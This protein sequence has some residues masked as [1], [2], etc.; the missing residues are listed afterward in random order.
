[1]TSFPVKASVVV[2]NWNGLHW[3]KGCFDA[4]NSQDFQDFE[5]ILADDASTDESVKFTLEHYPEVRVARRVVQGGFAKTANEGIRAASGEYIVLLNNDTL[6]SASW[7]QELVRAMDS[8]PRTVGSLA[9]SMRRMDNPDLI[10]SA[11]DLLTWYGQGLKR[12]NDMPVSGCDCSG[13]ILAA[14]A[15]A[16]LYRRELLDATGGFDEHFESYL[17]DI[18]LGLR[19]SLLGYACR[20]VPVAVVLHK[21][22]GSGIPKPAYIRL[23][24]RNRLMLFGK[25][26]PLRLLLRHLPQLFLGQLA[27]FVQYRRPIASIRGYLSLVT[28][29]PYMLR[30]RQRILRARTLSDREIDSLL[31]LSTDGIAVPHWLIRNPG[32]N[33]L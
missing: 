18:D 15:G 23:V 7:L 4:L 2:P 13:E 8:L 12:G 33:G 6:P 21:S 5:V 32:R 3:L 20:Y 10:D 11:G 22:H 28:K 9:S 25:S 29:I 17:E 31:V 30:E 19:G 24:T 16:A 27:L 1:M 26:I 14:C